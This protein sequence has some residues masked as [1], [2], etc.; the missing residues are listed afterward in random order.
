MY[1]LRVS[2]YNNGLLDMNLAETREIAIHIGGLC[3]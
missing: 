2:R 1:M 3:G